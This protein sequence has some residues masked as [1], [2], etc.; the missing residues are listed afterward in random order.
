MKAMTHGR[1]CRMR[2]ALITE[3]AA[4]EAVA[5]GEE[6]AWEFLEWGA[7]RTAADEGAEAE[8]RATKTASKCRRC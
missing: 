3:E 7:V 5:A 6:C 8:T 2:A 4:V 1:K